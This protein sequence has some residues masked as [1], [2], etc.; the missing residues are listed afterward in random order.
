MDS[1][2]TMLATAV[3]GLV[4]TAGAAWA[5][6][7]GAGST[8]EAA[9]IKCEGVNECK[10][11]GAC[12]TTHNACAGQNGCAGQGFMM[13]TPDECDQAKAAMKK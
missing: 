12:K 8:G 6:A 7:D 1:R 3:A 2:K 13:M 4:L 10:G 11:H 5:Q 9:K